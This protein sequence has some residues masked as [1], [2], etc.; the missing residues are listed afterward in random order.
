MTRRVPFRGGMRP[1]LFFVEIGRLSLCGRL[2]QRECTEL[3]ELASKIEFVLQFCRG[4][5]DTPCT[6][7][8]SAEVLLVPTLERKRKEG[9]KKGKD[10]VN[11]HEKKGAIQ[12]WD[13]PLPSLCRD[14]APE[15]V[16]AP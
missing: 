15:F 3:R 9:A 16:W 4:T 8:T 13:A 6:H 7:P 2:R 14:R 11:Q 1:F 12:G 10:K 5:S